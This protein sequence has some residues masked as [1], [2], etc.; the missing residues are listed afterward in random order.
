MKIYF[1]KKYFAGGVS[2]R[3][4]TL[5]ETL[6]AVFMLSTAIAATLTAANTGLRSSFYARDQITA[7]YLAQE[8]IEYIRNVRDGNWLSQRGWISGPSS[9]ESIDTCTAG[10]C[11][12]DPWNTDLALGKIRLC[13][14]SCPAF[15][16][17]TAR[18]VY[19]YPASESGWQDTPFVRKVNI[20]K[21]Q[22]GGA[23]E[24]ITITVTVSWGSS[25]VLVR[26]NLLNW[27]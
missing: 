26:E 6:V 4:F 7:Q 1:Q 27:K 20:Q 3:G 16:F 2:K 23:D 9:G 22:I 10:D 17:N 13:G 5:L 25:S 12:V 24:E 14:G 8:A 19:G 21:L 18:G 15:K 11:I